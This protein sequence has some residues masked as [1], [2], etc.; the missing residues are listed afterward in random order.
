MM[1]QE[2]AYADQQ[3]LNFFFL[4]FFLLLFYLFFL[5]ML[6]LAKAGPFEPTLGEQTPDTRPCP[7]AP[8]IG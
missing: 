5:M 2:K 4:F 6:N 3:M 8:C 1:S 7:Q